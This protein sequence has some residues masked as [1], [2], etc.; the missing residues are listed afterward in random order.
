MT[1]GRLFDGRDRSGPQPTADEYDGLAYRTEQADAL[2]LE[3]ANALDAHHVAAAGEAT[4]HL[5][6]ATCQLLDRAREWAK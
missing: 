4:V 1:S 3:L 5:C 2:V 6:C